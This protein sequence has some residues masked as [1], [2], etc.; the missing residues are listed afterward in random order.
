MGC[1][2]IMASYLFL[3]NEDIL[4]VIDE[5]VERFLIPRFLELDMNASGEWIKSLEVVASNNREAVIRG[6]DYTYYLVRGRGPNQDQSI[7][8]LRRW[9]VWA[10]NTFIKEWVKNKGIAAD[11]IAVAMSIA[12]KGTTWKRKG[13]SDLLEVLTETDTIQ[14]IEQKIRMIV[15]PR[16]VDALRRNAIDTLRNI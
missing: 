16:I 8:A 13:G 5:V 2:F 15:Q 3:T 1:F 6:R 7:E 12:K 14:F 11:P 4:L 10:G 9:A